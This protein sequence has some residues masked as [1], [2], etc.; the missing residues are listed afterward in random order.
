MKKFIYYFFASLFPLGV[1]AQET[2]VNGVNLD[3]V[4]SLTQVVNDLSSH[5]KKVEDD[6]RNESIWKK[7]S[8]YFQI[9]YMNQTLTNQDIPDLKWKSDFGVS[10]SFGRT[11]YL[12]KKPLFNMLKFGLD[13]TWMDISYAKYSQPEGWVEPSESSEQ[14][15]PSE[16]IDLGVHQVEFGLH[17]GPSITLNP[18]N[19]LKI[20][21]YFHFI[22]SGSIIIMNDE[23]NAS[24][25]TNFAV[26]GAIAYKAISLGIESRWGKAK[27]SSFSVDENAAD[28]E[29]ME[30]DFNV[31]D[32][33]VTGKNRMKTK[34][35]RFFLT[36]RF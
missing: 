10:L 19:H 11:F 31:D 7:R 25:V 6:K 20:S 5:V 3:K 30:E 9:G 13:A 27:Y 21:G 2:P 29:E 33:L 32:V 14:V 23:A 15:D 16:D 1:Y 34:S 8:K 18:V 17:V 28:F 35:L 36:F 12:H 4:D 26:G 24:Y 22:P